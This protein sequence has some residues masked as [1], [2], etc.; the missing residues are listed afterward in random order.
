M[1]VTAIVP[2]G[3]LEG[4]VVDGVAAFKGIPYAEPPVGD[5]RW[6][7][8]QPVTP[9]TGTR[10][11]TEF[12]PDC[13]QAPGDFEVLRTTP[14]EDC[15]YLNVWKPE[16]AAEGDRLPV[17]VWIHGGGYVG[18][19]TSCPYYD[20]SA[21]AREGIV[22]VSL[23]YRLGRFGFFAHPALI[24]AAEGPVGNFAYMDQIKALEWVRDN[25]AVFGGDPCRVTLIGQSAGGDSVVR[26]MTSPAVGDL[27]AQAMVLSGG[28]RRSLLDRP[29]T[30]G[31]ISDVSAATMDKW[32]AVKHRI[33]GEGAD[34]LAK[35]R[36]LDPAVVAG[37]DNVGI[38]GAKKLL[39]GSVAGVP[40]ID[41]DIV[42]DQ[43]YEVFRRGAATRVPLIIGS[44]AF[45]LP[46]HF[47]PSKIRPLEWFGDDEP[48]AREAYSVS[49]RRGDIVNHL[50]TLVALS[51][52]MTMHEPAHF[53]AS[54]M[55]AAGQPAWLFRF[56]YTAQCARPKSL[57]QGHSGELPFLFGTL[58][59]AYPG[60]VADRDRAMSD[61]FHRYVA[62]YVKD[63]DPNGEGLPEWPQI[64]PDEYELMNFT[65]DDG[66][67]FG[68]DPRR[69]VALVARAQERDLAGGKAAD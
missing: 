29:M 20:G 40:I 53:A 12:G 48:A 37:R 44:T 66:P 62:N 49:K 60:E 67:V 68:P 22:V 13:V 21:F 23:N 39:G 18:G 15:L 46:L 58:E 32:F 6:R 9:W 56:T 52:D 47:P 28:G 14:S 10:D 24:A 19:G 57:E 35:L 27:F 41:G 34:D 4:S 2:D 42:V 26:L 63:G 25:V 5:L 54:S 3:K 38:L 55:S 33:L 64:V 36:G 43:P 1:T 16:H 17:I 59:A 50:K 11:A 8:P 69:G 31:T 65:L 30:D 45:D 61:A 7:P 51:G